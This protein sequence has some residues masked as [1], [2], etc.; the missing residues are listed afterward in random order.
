MDKT[1]VDRM[2]DMERYGEEVLNANWLPQSVLQGL[3]AEPES[4]PHSHFSIGDPDAYMRLLY[5]TQE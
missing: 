5:Q 1:A 3:P 4:V 2:S